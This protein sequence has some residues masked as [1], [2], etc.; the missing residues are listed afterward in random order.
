MNKLEL[1]L[2]LL[3]KK[4]SAQS[5]LKQ[6]V[7]FDNFAIETFM[8]LA[9]SYLPGISENEAEN[10]FWYFVH[11]FQGEAGL[12]RRRMQ[13]GLNVFDALFYYADDCLTIQ[14]NCVLCKYSKLIRW[15]QMIVEV[16]EDLLVSAYLA[17]EDLYEAQIQQRGFLWKRVIGHNNVRLN[18]L[19]ERGISENHFHLY[20]S[21][22]IFHISWM[23]LMNNVISSKFA[24]KLREYDK[25]RRYSNKA[26]SGEYQE[27]SFYHQYLQAALI[28]LLLYSKITGQRIHIGNYT[29]GAPFVLRLLNLPEYRVEGTIKK[30][31]PSKLQNWFE[32]S[33][34]QELQ[35]KSFFRELYLCSADS[36]ETMM[37]ELEENAA[38]QQF[39]C[40]KIGAYQI[41]KQ[42]ILH[43]L[44]GYHHEISVKRLMEDILTNV[45][46]IN[47]EDV[48]VS[49]ADNKMFL[50]AW[51]EKTRENV[52]NLLR[53]PEYLEEHIYEIQPAIDAFRFPSWQLHSNEEL[54]MDYTL[55]QLDKSGISCQEPF[56]A[57]A[58]ERWLLYTMLRRIY[59]GDPAY[60]GYY[61]LFYAYVLLKERIRSE[62]VQSNDNVGFKNFE[63]YQDRKQELLDDKIYDN[64][65]VKLTLRETLL[66][67]N[68]QTL[69]LRITPCDTVKEI[70]R[71]I[72]EL[73][74]LIDPS[75]QYRHR[76]FYTLHFIKLP[77]S[78]N[79]S[80]VAEV[81]CRHEHKRENLKVQTNA[82]VGLRERYPQIAQRILGIDAAA[83]EIGCRPQVFG[84]Y[85][86]YLK[87]Q[88]TVYYEADGQHKLPQLRA[89]YHVGEDFLDVADGLRAIEEAVLFLN[90]DCGDR[91]GHALA[92]G[93]D[94][95]E[96]YQ[97]KG[98]HIVLPMQ[99][100]L[101]NI[102]WIYH[103][104]CEYNIQGFE[105]LKDI[106]HNEFVEYFGMIY[107]NNISYKETDLILQR[108]GKNFVQLDFNLFNYYSSMKLRGDEPKYYSLGY[109]DEEAYLEENE[110]YAINRK[111]DVRLREMPDIVLM[112]YHY[113]FNSAA[114]KMGEKTI[115]KKVNQDY[116]RAVQKIQEFMQRD[117]AARGI[118]IE[119]NP[120]SNYLIGT[121]R[122]YAKHPII[123]FFNRGLTADLEEMQSCPQI[124]VSIN[125]DDQG[126]FSTSLE[127]EYALIACALEE[128]ED[129]EGNNVYNR[130]MIYEWLDHVRI[131]GNEQSFGVRQY[132]EALEN[133]KSI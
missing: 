50:Q 46:N 121:F 92:L 3:Y 101:D 23:S 36:D 61:H 129:E 7:Q 99:D 15:R 64:A 88:T 131:M 59:K 48:V 4:T 122:K 28:R 49:G 90:L 96:W 80:E 117:I 27:V 20:G 93:I 62:I 132:R 98:G 86:R 128:V 75:K 35:I 22:P 94:V 8:R 85:F 68:I 113:H 133:R 100:Y 115:Q 30:F 16:S 63:K 47:L 12:K 67:E 57:F 56:F 74:N 77:D 87:R 123:R 26:Y 38:Y 119:T 58:G 17:Q 65:F 120:S 104:L 83:N 105:N 112:Y 76:F 31:S 97:F 51:E 130:N 95:K 103:K 116:I 45:G 11:T 6:E 24:E 69:E 52:Q 5:V 106:L 108:S 89:T 60:R 44:R 2:K 25:N 10:M 125:T 9:V 84:R 118:S 127:N 1:I 40:H 41:C 114:R 82:I 111:V 19:L 107:G 21:A 91:L 78:C 70:R 55:R 66:T 42:D 54:E 81:R 14:N 13:S 124:A 33:G 109:F 37:M 39:V 34:R 102:V 126:V 73:D 53:N 29:V 32:K 72:I 71:R 110:K 43:I 79:Q 18:L